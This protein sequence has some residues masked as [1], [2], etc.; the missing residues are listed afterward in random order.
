MTGTDSLGICTFSQ[1]GQSKSL[2]SDFAHLTQEQADIETSARQYPSDHTVS[3]AC[4]QNQ[5]KISTNEGSQQKAKTNQL[6]QGRLYH[7][8]HSRVLENGPSHEKVRQD[9]YC[10]PVESSLNLMAS[11]MTI[12][13]ASSLSTT[14]QDFPDL[15]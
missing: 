13:L 14:R 11:A 8:N 5:F 2:P 7:K 1:D 12:P 4:S 15:K 6:M 9:S 3:L 10:L